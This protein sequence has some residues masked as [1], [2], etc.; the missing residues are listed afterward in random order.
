MTDLPAGRTLP[1]PR[2]S[3][4]SSNRVARALLVLLLAEITLAVYLTIATTS[5]QSLVLVAAGL[6]FAG[7]TGWIEARTRRGETVRSGD[8][9]LVGTA[10]LSL[11][12]IA[13]FA[14]DLWLPLAATLVIFTIA[15]AGILY[16]RSTSSRPMLFSLAA[17]AAILA[18][19]LLA[20]PAYR[21]APPDALAALL[22]ALTVAAIAATTLYV[23]R[24]FAALSLRQKLVIS[25]LFL[26]LVPM[27]A[28][29]YLYDLSFRA[30]L[31]ESANQNLFSVASQTANVIDGFID[32]NLN[33]V[34]IQARL[35]TFI[36][37]LEIRPEDPAYAENL[38]EATELI[39]SLHELN[40]DSFLVGHTLLDRAG[41]I[42]LDSSVPRGL[43]NP[44]IGENLFNDPLFFNPALQGI[45]YASPL[46]VPGGMET[47]QITFGH[48]VVNTDGQPVGVFLSHYSAAF[49]QELLVANEGLAGEG[50]Y[51]ILFDENEIFLA[52]ARQPELVFAAAAPLDP[53]LREDLIA[54]GR[55]PEGAGEV[56]SPGFTE[57]A[58][59]LDNAA[60]TPFFTIE[61]PAIVDTP[62]QVATVRLSNYPWLVAFFQP[63]EVFLEPLGAQTFNS[64]LLAGLISAGAIAVA[65]LASNQL[66]GPILRLTEAAEEVTAGNLNVTAEV[67]AQDEVGTLAEAFNSMTRQLR[68][69]LSGLEG[70]VA[71]RTSRLE[72]T[73][74]VG[75]VAASILNR[76]DLIANIV[77][78]IADK[79]GYYYAAIFLV[80][81]DETWAVLHS[82]TGEAGEELKARG[83]RLQIGGRSMVGSA[84]SGREARIALD[85]GE[86]PVRFENPLL[87]RTRSEIALPLIVGD[88]VLGAL[89]VQSTEPDDFDEQDLETLQTLAGQVAIA[90]EN[91][92]LFERIQRSAVTQKRMSEFAAHIQQAQ[93]LDGILSTAVREIAG[94]MEASEITVRLAPG[95]DSPAAGNGGSPNGEGGHR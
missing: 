75:R 7:L 1:A 79:F 84:I 41:T 30:S 86:E 32:A 55:L 56:D 14:A 46:R 25:F 81:E 83:H 87:P 36:D 16:P 85:A 58:E 78:L 34:E 62:N 39:Y 2:P 91:A 9:L 27:A 66:A 47:A 64:L 74:E 20:A 73:N 57:L 49:L 24:Q 93:D 35:P 80:D 70:I 48:V 88:T 61:D 69:M 45:P 67:A 94:I 90:L 6:G 23:L 12:L 40:A 65:I 43:L 5:W 10:W 31:T 77:D 8:R 60:R 3:P 19:D 82:A 63:Q 76:D 28:I 92:V 51:G 50:S 21:L 17:A 26:A 44:A 13:L 53:G 54:Q 89:D 38:A 42:V 68:D 29:R 11:I 22:P 18:I 95:E 72:A 33:S 15:A 59:K 4:S 52:H 37:L 71:E